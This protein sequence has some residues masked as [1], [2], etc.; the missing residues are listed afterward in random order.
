MNEAG[1]D[2]FFLFDVEAT[3]NRRFGNVNNKTLLR[4]MLADGTVI[5]STQP[6]VNTEVEREK[7]RGGSDDVVQTNMDRLFA[8]FDE[9]VK[10]TPIPAL[11]SESARRRV[12]QLIH[13]DQASPLQTLFEARLYH[14]MGSLTTDELATI[15]QIVLRGNEGES[16]AKGLAADRKLVMDQVIEQQL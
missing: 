8:K 10:L 13:D 1:Y 5:A 7:M 4:V 6:L 14:S 2:G 16:L 3:L 15:Y 11:P 12:Q 9:T